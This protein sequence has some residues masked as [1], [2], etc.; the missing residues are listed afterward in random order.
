[1]G[2]EE[3]D[4]DEILNAIHSLKNVSSG[5]DGIKP[6]VIKF[7]KNEL[8]QPLCHLIN[9]MFQSGIYPDIFK[10]AIVIPINKSGKKNDIK[11]YRPVSILTSFNK[12]VEKILY[13]RIMNFV[14]KNDLLHKKQFGF[15]EKSNTETAVI[16]LVNDIRQHI[17]KKKESIVNF[18]GCQQSI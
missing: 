8:A 1:M 9:K 16:E 17:D 2:L 13:K 6:Q 5:I 12:V 7:L 11:D 4:S 3:T 15:R 14:Q 10:T 18:H